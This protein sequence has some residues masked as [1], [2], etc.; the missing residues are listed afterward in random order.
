MKKFAKYLLTLG[1]AALSFAACQEEEVVETV[2]CTVSGDSTF[3]DYKA[4]ITVTA[5]K[6]A[7]ED[8]EVEIRL[9]VSSTFSADQLSFPASIKVAKGQTEATATVEIK[10]PNSL[11]PG[12]YK[13][14]FGA[15]I[16]GQGPV[17]EKITITWTK[18]DI[19][20]KWSI[21]GLGGDWNTDIFL[22][23]ADGGWYAKEGVV[24]VN[25]GESFKFRKGASW[26]LALGLTAE[27]NAPLDK[28][29]E[30]SDAPGGP[31]IGIEKEGIYT[32]SV[33]PNHK[34]AKVVRTADVDYVYSFTGPEALAENAKGELKAACNRPV[35]SDVTVTITATEN[36]FPEGK[37]TFPASLVIAQGTQEATGEIAVGALDYGEYKVVLKATIGETEVATLTYTIT[38]AIPV[39]TLADLVALMPETNKAKADFECILNNVVVTYVSGSNIFLEDETAA[40]LLY[41][42]I[43]GIA[44][45]MKLSGHFVGK[46]QNYNKLPEISDL[47]FD[48]EEVTFEQ[49][50][51]PAPTE[52]TIADIN[53]NFDKLIS[54]RVKLVNVYAGADI[55][56]KG[57]Y[58]IYQGESSIKFY[59][60]VNLTKGFKAGSIFDVVAV[61]TPYNDDKQVKIFEEASITRLIPVMNVA[62]LKALCTSTSNAS[63]AGVFAGIYVNYVLSN[64]H[65]Y[66]ED[67]S[68]AIRFYLGS[69]NT[70]KVGDKLS[71]VLTGTACKDGNGRPQLSWL[72][73][74]YGKVETAPEA[75][76]PK[77]VTGNLADFATNYDN[78]L[79]R[80]VQ[81]EGVVLDVDSKGG[82]AISIS[83]GTGSFKIWFNNAPSPVIPAGSKIAF[84]GTFDK[85][86]SAQFIKVFQKSEAHQ[87]VPAVQNLWGVYS[88]TAALWT[89]NI[90][91]ISITHPDGYGMARGLA[92]DDQYIYLPKSSAYPAIAAIK[93][94]DPT[95]QIKGDVSTVDAG[96][97]FKSCFVR[98]I[99]NTDASVNGGKDILL[100]SNCTAANGGNVVIYAYTGGITAAPIKLAQFAWDS[101]NSVEDWRRYGDRFFVTGTW[102]DGKIYLPSFHA[103]KTVVLSV[104]NGARTAVTQIAAGA[105]NSP[106][107]IKD[108]TV[109]P[110][111]TK[112]FITNNSI[113]NLV[114]P[115]GGKSAQGW[116]EYTLS[117]SSANGKGTWGYNFFTFEGKKYIAY[118]RISGNKAWIEVVEDK[119]DLL[120][121]LADQTG[122]LKAPLHSA[123]NLDAE[124]ETGGLADCCVRTIGGNVFLVGLTRDGGASVCQMVLK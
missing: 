92:M 112:L 83:D 79:F 54:K 20:G 89:A 49:G 44:A 28:E 55:K 53:A 9:D 104:A 12:D 115:T 4:T 34:K 101:A 19:S 41:K 7:V 84:T 5:D 106:E 14:V 110:D 71:G 78:L 50:E 67:E 118:A 36:T 123:T 21:I 85:N 57:S 26:D 29:F 2:N 39:M 111:D 97:T 23:E 13:A 102:Q 46:V 77:P 8:L 122:L 30:V 109:Y 56:N 58:D 45:G 73:T 74:T 61:V 105:D 117:D 48:Q 40:M 43:P 116:D 52:M 38:K 114:A 75:E 81:M 65:I 68:G 120:T 24:V 10:D 95:T 72:D 3:K 25:D 99:K 94:S 63:F 113:A 82:A 32:I 62:D 6:A 124:F 88:S 35:K 69:G 90:Q 119:G 59:T 100:M 91:A 103:N 51:A 22:D 121:S 15:V 80:R 1:I 98:T 64:Q 31:N 60:N 107:G 108:M 16:L 27:G 66:L 37:L 87:M 33:N 93:I 96:D 18:E 17:G 86:T 76:M 70:L 42:N 47:T 11:E